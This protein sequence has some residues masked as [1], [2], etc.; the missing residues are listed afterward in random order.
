[1]YSDTLDVSN[2]I[3][4]DGDLLEIFE[5][6]KEDMDENIRIC[7]EETIR[8]EKYE[9]NYQQWTTKDFRGKFIADVYFYDSTNIH[10]DTYEAFISVFHNRI[11]E[12]KNINIHFSYSYETLEN[13]IMNMQNQYID[14]TI[15]E[16]KMSISVHLKSTDNKMND[17][18]NII[19]DKILNAPEKYDRIIKKRSAICTKAMIA[20][21]IIPSIIICTLL[22]FV[23][24]I[25]ELYGSTYIL[26]PIAVL[27]LGFMIGGTIFSRKMDALY[28]TIM[29]QRKY[30]GYDSK[31]HNTVY[32]DDV[33]SYI[34][35]SEIIIGK[36]IDNLNKR[37]KIKE[38]DEQYSR[39][40][41]IELVVIL[42]MSLV[43]I[44]ISQFL[45]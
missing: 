10:F 27:L 12:I 34:N 37:N 32:K 14:L 16:N 38:L 40:I 41:P 15:K 3:I 29:P 31:N 22:A 7:N 42:G 25:R 11:Q 1:M 33:D 19:K 20:L 28:S 23:P 4:S 17:V 44:V 21:G 13:G 39:Y 5:K 36:N 30:A 18:Y 45:G 26:Y 35:S 24:S 8:N 2:K 6:M 9:R 43:I